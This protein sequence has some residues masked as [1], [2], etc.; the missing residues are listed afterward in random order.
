MGLM[1]W[2]AIAGVALFLGVLFA[3][4]WTYATGRLK[5]ARNE[6][7][8][9]SRWLPHALRMKPLGYGIYRAHDER[10]AAREARE[11]DH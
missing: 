10:R 4:A 7:Q 5:G 3:L 11:E 8:T 9:R 1:E 2:T 6:A